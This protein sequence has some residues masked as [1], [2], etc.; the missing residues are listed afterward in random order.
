MRGC[1]VW[2]GREDESVG[3]GG[4][5]MGGCAVVYKA[6]CMSVRDLRSG[7]DGDH[8]GTWAVHAIKTDWTGRLGNSNHQPVRRLASLTPAPHS[9]I[10]A[11]RPL[12]T[13][14]TQSTL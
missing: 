13:K 1:D 8:L 11:S 9:R 12:F 4:I 3:G 14:P 10:I 6:V 7:D 5:R 2:C